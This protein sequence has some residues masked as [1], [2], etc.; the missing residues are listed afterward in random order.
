MRKISGAAACLLL[1]LTA[2]R[3]DVY[4]KI[5]LE[6]PAYSPV[7][8]ENYQE[9]II[10]DFLVTGKPEG[11]DLNREIQEYFR[12]ELE[13]KFKGKVSVRPF[14][15][16]SEE[17]FQ[18]ADYW[19]PLAAGSGSRLIMTGKAQLSEEIRK[20]ILSRP[21]RR[22][23]DAPRSPSRDIE[24]RRVFTLELNL[25]LIKAE[26][27]E[28]LLQKEFKEVKTYVN[29]RQRADFAFH[30]LAQRVRTRLFRPILGEERNQDR[31]LLLR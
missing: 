11:L 22:I 20:A 15:V 21:A 10:T 17:A 6:L 12:L 27:G 5:R 23:D 24:E 31:Y 13:I 8:L 2:C 18:S 7:N 29:L 19:K 16:E 30:D 28:T 3:G 25:Y 26:T 1:F 14:P 9:V 4:Q